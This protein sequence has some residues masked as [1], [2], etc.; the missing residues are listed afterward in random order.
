MI[1]KSSAAKTHASKKLVD[2]FSS[3]QLPPI[4]LVDLFFI[5]TVESFP[6]I[7]KSGRMK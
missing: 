1:N 7:T 6:G 3:L 4:C 5:K 2:F